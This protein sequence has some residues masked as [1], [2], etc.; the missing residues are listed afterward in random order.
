MPQYKM[1][2]T[3]RGEVTM[4]IEAEDESEAVVEAEDH[5]INRA[6]SLKIKKKTAVLEIQD[7]DIDDVEES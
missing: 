4:T 1:T 5:F 7:V 6:I 2:L 3:I